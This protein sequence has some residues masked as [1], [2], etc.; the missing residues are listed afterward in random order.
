[1][2]CDKSF[3]VYEILKQNRSNVDLTSFSKDD[4]ING[5]KLFIG[6][7][8]SDEDFNSR[9]NPINLKERK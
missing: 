5:I 3:I 6:A 8:R 7:C 1:M 2:E 9:Y 4:L